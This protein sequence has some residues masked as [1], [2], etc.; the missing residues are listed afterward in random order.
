M[1]DDSKWPARVALLTSAGMFAIILGFFDAYGQVSASPVTAQATS[2]SPSGTESP[3]TSP[4]P[5]PTASCIVPIPSSLPKPSPLCSTPAPQPSA[6]ASSTPTPSPT[7]TRTPTTSPSPSP[8]SAQP[9]EKKSTVT[10]VYKTAPRRFVGRVGSAEICIRERPIVV[11]K[12][13]EGADPVIGKGRTDERGR[14]GIPTKS[15]SGGRYYAVVRES[16]AGKYGTLTVCGAARS[17]TIR[18]GW[19]R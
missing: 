15:S 10:I 17:K 8:T 14:Y 7:L 11:R 1:I 2:A 4:S 13:R 9:R 5:S 3:A 19:E 16:T 18:L 6:S 12:V